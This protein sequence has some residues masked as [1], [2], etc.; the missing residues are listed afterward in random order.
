MP[1]SESIK[2][3]QARA[4][5]FPQPGIGLAHSTKE[6]TLKQIMPASIKAL[7]AKGYKLVSVDECLGIKPYQKVYWT[8]LRQSDVSASCFPSEAGSSSY[9]LLGSA[10]M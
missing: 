9:S 7:K 6:A 3:I 2:H 4:R 5:K 1:T 8:K 10:R